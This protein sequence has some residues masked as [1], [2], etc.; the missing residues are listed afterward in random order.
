M[1]LEGL[2]LGDKD[3]IS[4]PGAGASPFNSTEYMSVPYLGASPQTKPGIR[5]DPRASATTTLRLL[6]SDTSSDQYVSRF[7]TTTQLVV[8]LSQRLCIHDLDAP[9]HCSTALFRNIELHSPGS[10][11]KTDSDIKVSSSVVESSRGLV[12]HH[13]W[14]VCYSR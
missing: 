5:L 7:M 12:A 4:E 8:G 3:S 9:L 13:T 1:T 11:L 6:R 14:L 10:L 2:S